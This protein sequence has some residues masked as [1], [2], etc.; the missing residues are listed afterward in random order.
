MTKSKLKESKTHNISLMLDRRG[1][2][3][4]AYVSCKKSQGKMK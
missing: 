2:N 3:V 4:K 1:K